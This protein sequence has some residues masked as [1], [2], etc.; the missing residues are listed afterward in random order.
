LG[1]VGAS[2]LFDLAAKERR[3]SHDF[4]AWSSILDQQNRYVILSIAT[5]SLIW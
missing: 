5:L 1:R 4:F 2:Q 3:K